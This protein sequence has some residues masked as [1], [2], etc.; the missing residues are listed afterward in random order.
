MST[1]SN[2]LAAAIS[3]VESAVVTLN[4]ADDALIAATAA[5]R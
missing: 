2:T 3:I 4:G 5:K 1:P